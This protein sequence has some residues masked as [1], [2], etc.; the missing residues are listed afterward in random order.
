MNS[1]CN[2]GSKQLSRIVGAI[3]LIAGA[4]L[5]L[6]THSEAGILGFFIAGALLCMKR[7]SGCNPCGGCGSCGCCCGCYPANSGSVESF[8][9]TTIMPKKVAKAPAKPRKPKKSV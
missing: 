1:T 7:S 8:C 5:T 4:G 9:E 6:M 2:S 3:F